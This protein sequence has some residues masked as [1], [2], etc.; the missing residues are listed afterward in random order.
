SSYELEGKRYQLEKAFF[1]ADKRMQNFNV[2]PELRTAA[3][4]TYLV[5]GYRQVHLL[6]TELFPNMASSDSLHPVE[7][8]AA[9]IAG[10]A[11]LRAGSIFIGGDQ[12]DS[13]RAIL[14]QVLETDYFALKHHHEA[15]LLAGHV[16]K[17]QGRWLD[18]ENYYM[19]LLRSYYPPVV[20]G[21]LPV[22]EVLELPKTIVGHYGALGDRETAAEKA[23]WAVTY[24]HNLLKIKELGSTP[25]SLMVTRF[26][27]EMYNA[28]GQY[29]KSAALLQTVV[30]STGAVL[31]AA[32]VLIADLY[33]TRLDKK[34]EAVEIYQDIVETT[35]DS[36]LKARVYLKL[37]TIAFGNKIYN[38][39]R[40]YLEQLKKEYGRGRQI[41]IQA[42]QL[43]ARSF[44]DEGEWQR[45]LQEYQFLLAQYPDSPEALEVLSYLP[46]YCEKI[47]QPELV[48]TWTD[49]AETELGKIVNEH[50]GRQ[51][52]LMASGHLARFYLMHEKPQQAIDQLQRI[53]REYPKS[54]HAADA[55]LKIG[56]IYDN[57]LNNPQSAIAA[58]E[59][60]VKLYPN[61]IVRGKV[62]KEIERL[63]K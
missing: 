15:L 31:P 30:D 50:S 6:F 27:A 58:Y 57:N 55:L 11:L 47:G 12:V 17:R 34:K 1:E 60:F 26:L 16:A 61:S 43:L 35:Q 24:Y 56:L 23:N 9:F 53:R 3:D 62:E 28:I 40:Q 8:E 63:K 10:R 2:K 19:E 22:I 36:L 41:S 21:I 44:E 20:N 32:R 13:A 33:F 45:A 18:A 54:A 14:D 7:M 39:G 46:D 49:K 51:L 5:D 52:G 29:D 48:K 37:A 38:R 59:E 25:F 4:F 42:Q